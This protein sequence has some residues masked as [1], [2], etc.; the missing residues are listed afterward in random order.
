MLVELVRALATDSDWSVFVELVR[1][2]E[3]TTDSEWSGLAELP[4]EELS[5]DSPWSVLR[6]LLRQGDPSTDSEW[7]ALVELPREETTDSPWSNLLS[8]VTQDSAWSALARTALPENSPPE[9]LEHL[10]VVLEPQTSM[11][12]DLSQ[13]LFDPDGDSI[14]IARTSATTPLTVS[15]SGPGD[16]VVDTAFTVSASASGGVGPYSY[17]GEWSYP[18]GSQ[19]YGQ[20]V[21]A[22]FRVL[23]V[24]TF[25]VTVT[26]DDGV[27]ATDSYSL[28]VRSDVV[29]NPLTVNISG[30][31]NS[32]AGTPFTVS[33]SASGGAGPYSYASLWTYPGGSTIYGQSISNTFAVLG[34]H[35]F[36]TT[37]TDADGITATDSYSLNVRSDV[38][39][40]PLTVSLS[41]PGDSA[42]DTPF[43]TSA[44]ASGGAPPYSYASLWSYPGGSLHYGQSVSNTFRVLGTHT[45][46]VT[47][48]DSD[49]VT[50]TD[51]HSLTV[52]S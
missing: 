50:A 25:S 5:T 19:L 31:G 49:S 37:V 43:T 47:V 28:N 10:R 4:R 13:Y 35:T 52:S 29:V 12:L 1:A 2:G 36:T 6:E 11:F 23:G 41:G 14:T 32:V 40:D 3:I 30:P 33:A 26:D 34:T 15:L 39:V 7:S 9:C 46:T 16:S 21:S 24:H 45:F 44:S 38:V 42:V 27:T 17:S 18:G 22:T 8:N 48:T 20:S 51:S